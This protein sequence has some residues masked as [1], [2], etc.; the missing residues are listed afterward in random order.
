MRL[1]GS[2]GTGRKCREA[3]GGFTWSPPSMPPCPCERARDVP[4]DVSRHR[5]PADASNIQFMTH[6]RWP[7]W[8]NVML[9]TPLVKGA[10]PR[11]RDDA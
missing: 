3:R 6:H 1:H 10:P 2:N 8:N 4:R 9:L 7:S 5:E 11:V